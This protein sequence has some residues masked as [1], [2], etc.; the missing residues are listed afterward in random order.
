MQIR[1]N[2]I[3]VPKE[4]LEQV[5]NQ[6]IYEIKM[7]HKKKKHW[8]YVI[9]GTAAA[10][11][12]LALTGIFASNPTFAA[13]LPLV[14]HIFERVQDEQNYP[15]NFDEVAEPVADKNVSEDQGIKIT[16]SEIYSDS[17]A[18][19]VSAMVESKDPF[20]EA[21]K[22]SNILYGDDIGYRIQLGIEQ[23]LDFM[24]PPKTYDPLEW[25]GD[26]YTWTPL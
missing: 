11:A 13:K 5:V 22:T 4:R 26:E 25:P 19:Y 3:D 17:R 12:V 16:L 14:G 1:F 9:R 24:T 7:Q 18:M 6:N 10:A 23:E 21:V 2:D 20:P 15:G 8:N